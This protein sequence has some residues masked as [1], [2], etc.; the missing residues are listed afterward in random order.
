YDARRKRTCHHNRS[1]ETVAPADTLRCRR[2]LVLV[3]TD[4]TRAVRQH[5]REGRRTCVSFNVSPAHS[6]SGTIVEVRSCS[7]SWR[8]AYLLRKAPGTPEGQPV[9]ASA[10]V[11]PIAVAHVAVV[12]VN[13]PH[14]RIVATGAHG[15]LF[16]ADARKVSGT[17]NDKDRDRT[18]DCC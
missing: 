8:G 5:C 1:D 7:R 12:R 6:A 13:T 9:Q 3:L 14:E 16:G 18:D 17:I 10:V 11:I 2:M 4:A 15:T